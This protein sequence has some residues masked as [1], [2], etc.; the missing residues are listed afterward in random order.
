MEKL[1]INFIV[2]F[3]ILCLLISLLFSIFS[4][5]S[6]I[7]ILLNLAFSSIV[8]AG[9]GFVVYEILSKRVPELLE[10]FNVNSSVSKRSFEVL[11]ESEF[12][13]NRESIEE[14]TNEDIKEEV[15]EPEATS[16]PSSEN[17]IKSETKHFGDHIIVNKVSIKNEPK[18]MAQAIRT[19][20]SKDDS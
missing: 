2:V 14:E 17:D 7:S 13:V 5:N 15:V 16:I 4:G 11:E 20:L 1:K 19:M 12:D 9:I 8:G 3:A 10:I 18:L 6:L